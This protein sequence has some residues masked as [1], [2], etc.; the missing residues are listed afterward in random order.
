MNSIIFKNNTVS[1]ILAVQLKHN[2]NTCFLMMIFL[3]KKLMVCLHYF[4]VFFNVL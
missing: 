4:I 3:F 2:L 1:R